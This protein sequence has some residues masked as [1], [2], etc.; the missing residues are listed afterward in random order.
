MRLLTILAAGLILMTA[1]TDAQQV[2]QADEPVLRYE[3][4]PLP[5]GDF[6]IVPLPPTNGE[7]G[8]NVAPMPDRPNAVVQPDDEWPMTVWQEWDAKYADMLKDQAWYARVSADG[9]V[10]DWYVL[11][12]GE[13]IPA[14]NLQPGESVVRVSAPDWVTRIAPSGPQIRAIVEMLQQNVREAICNMTDRPARFGSEVDV[15]AGIGISGRIA[16]SVEWETAE[17]CT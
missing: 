6:N 12:E 8:T 17:L 15:S 10:V 1:A 7:D 14:A 4:Q 13:T 2:H 9:E 3:V 16:F 11:P 5:G